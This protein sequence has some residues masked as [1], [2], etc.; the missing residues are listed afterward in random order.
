MWERSP[1]YQRG[2]TPVEASLASLLGGFDFLES[3]FGK[4]FISRRH[5]LH[6]VTEFGQLF[7]RDH[8]ATGSHAMEVNCFVFGH[9][10]DEFFRGH[11]GIK[12]RH[13]EELGGFQM[14]AVPLFFGAHINE[15]RFAIVNGFF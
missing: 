10:F 4:G 3:R 14:A 12:A 5:G 1:A 15:D 11:I 13:G 2:T 6:L 8:A 9:E 7:R